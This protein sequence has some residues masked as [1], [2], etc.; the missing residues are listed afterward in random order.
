MGYCA[1][2]IRDLQQPADPFC[3]P[4]LD[5]YGNL[6][7]EIQDHGL[8]HMAKATGFSVHKRAANSKE[9]ETL[10]YCFD[11]D[12]EFYVTDSRI[13][14]RCLKYDNGDR[15]WR[16]GLTALALNAYEKSKSQ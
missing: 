15:E 4:A 10:I 14:L 1:I 9:W 2:K 8:N 5:Q 16:G 11:L 12:L 13:I 6:I 7:E 3:D